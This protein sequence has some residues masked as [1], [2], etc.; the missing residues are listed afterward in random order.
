MAL[1]NVSIAHHQSISSKNPATLPVPDF[2]II[3]ILYLEKL[4]AEILMVNGLYSNGYIVENHR[5]FF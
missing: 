4:W 1:E 5:H 2:K 3:L